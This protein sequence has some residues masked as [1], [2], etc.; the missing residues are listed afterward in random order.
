MVEHE[1]VPVHKNDGGFGHGGDSAHDGVV[2]S[3]GRTER[4]CPA[5]VVLTQWPEMGGSASGK[6]N[7]EWPVV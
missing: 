5:A 7:V 1:L 3:K 4:R 6:K 2:Q